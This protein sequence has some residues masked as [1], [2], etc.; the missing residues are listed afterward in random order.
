MHGQPRLS[1]R[2]I[3]EAKTARDLNCDRCVQNDRLVG[4]PRR[5]TQ[6]EHSVRK[7]FTMVWSGAEVLPNWGSAWD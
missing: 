2:A 4:R 7:A 5:G 6:G 3:L 1:Y